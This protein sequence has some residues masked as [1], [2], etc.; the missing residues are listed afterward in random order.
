MYPVAFHSRKLQPAEI[1]YDTHDK[2]LL[3]IVD[4]FKVWR[5][6]LEGSM[7]QVQVHSDHQTLKSFLTKK[8]INC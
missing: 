1:N 5:R 3:A 8:T 6:Y 2:E 4:S 7:H